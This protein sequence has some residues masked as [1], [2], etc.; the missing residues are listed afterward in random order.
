MGTAVDDGNPVQQ[1]RA[2]ARVAPPRRRRR[3]SGGRYSVSW[4]VSAPGVG[5]RLNHGHRHG[6][7]RGAPRPRAEARVRPA[8]PAGADDDR[9]GRGRRAHGD[10]P[11]H[12]DRRQRRPPR[13]PARRSADRLLRPSRRGLRARGGRRPGRRLRPGGRRDRGLRTAPAREAGERL[14]R[15]LHGPRLQGLVRGRPPVE[16][17]PPRRLTAGAQ[18]PRRAR[19]RRTSIPADC[20]GFYLMRRGRRSLVS[21][22]MPR[23]DQR[24]LLG[25][26][27]LTLLFALVQSATGI[28]A[29]VLL[30]APV[31]LILLPLLAGRY[32]GEDGLARLTA[33]LVPRRRR[34]AVALP[35]PPRRAPRV[36]ARG[37]RP[38]AVAPAPRAPR[39]AQLALSRPALLTGAG[40]GTREP[41]V[42]PCRTVRPGA[43]MTR[44]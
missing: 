38:I 19:T 3:A 21:W 39:A 8:R 41:A 24:L 42:P 5:A 35:A 2:L 17:L 30:A 34:A 7:T 13:G 12:G 25:L 14:G 33:P 4:R 22:S 16:P 1:Q 44:L 11:R 36:L 23:R 20:C 29:D 27:A 10:A 9:P 18:A 15:R 31:L 28:S 37:G 32:V 43:T 26:A 40:G 6:H